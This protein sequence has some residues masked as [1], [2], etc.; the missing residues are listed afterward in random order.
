MKLLNSA[1]CIGGSDADAYSS[2]SAHLSCVQLEVRIL[3]ARHLSATFGK[4]AVYAAQQWV[5][6]ASAIV[7]ERYFGWVVAGSAPSDPVAVALPRVFAE[8][9]TVKEVIEALLTSIAGEPVACGEDCFH[10]APSVALDSA[11][12]A[13][14]QV[15]QHDICDIIPAQAL[16]GGEAVEDSDEWRERY[17]RDMA[18]ATALLADMRAGNLTF[19]TQPILLTTG[20]H[21]GRSA[22]YL[23]EECLLRRKSEGTI[24]RPVALDILAVER[25]GL[26]RV[27]DNFIVHAV[28]DRL[29][30]E[31]EVRLGANISA[32]SAACDGWWSHLIGELEKRRDLA[33]RLVI[34]ITETAS[35]TSLP[36]ATEFAKRMRNLGCRIAMDDFGAGLYAIR[37]LVALAPDIVKIDA[38][39]I[40]RARV[41][42]K[43][44][45]ALKPIVGLC[46]ALG[47]IVVAEGIE[48]ASDSQMA[49]VAGA[50]WQQGYFIEA[51]GIATDGQSVTR[52]FLHEPPPAFGR[53][54][55]AVR[56]ATELAD[57]P[58]IGDVSLPDTAPSVLMRAAYWGAPISF[59]LWLLR[60]LLKKVD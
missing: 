59:A 34:E 28:I 40:R 47:G 46:S 9:S 36:A 54:R 1:S 42:D 23:Y 12:A 26:V 21:V 25:L 33:E 60:A 6:K 8:S 53:R 13:S 48:S 45:R 43:V 50:V 41:S 27:L 4:D 52:G 7:A 32:Q 37:N 16:F 30:D 56:A 14:L 18:V 57:P 39:F 29:A 38:L 44:R 5:L 20:R 49:A 58:S 55:E 35:L 31:P 2:P 10:V 17:R 15:G 24:A 19:T 51:P 11:A 22:P 3:N